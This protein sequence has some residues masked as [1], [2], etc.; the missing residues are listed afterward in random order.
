[1]MISLALPDRNDF[2]VDLYPNVTDWLKI[3][4]AIYPN[5]DG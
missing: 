2:N 4:L 5:N 1:M 3:W